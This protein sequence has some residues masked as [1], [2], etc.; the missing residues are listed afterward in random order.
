M[1]DLFE[2]Q[3]KRNHISP[4]PEICSEVP[5]H[6]KHCTTVHESTPFGIPEIY[7]FRATARIDLINHFNPRTDRNLLV[8]RLNEFIVNLLLVDADAFRGM[9]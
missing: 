8:R 5:H 6:V 4:A 1:H 3:N 2:G 9:L 7:L